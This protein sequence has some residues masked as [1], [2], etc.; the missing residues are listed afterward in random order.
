MFVNMNSKERILTAMRGETPDRVPVQLGITNM[1]SVRAQGHSGWD[2]FVDHAIPYWKIVTDTARHFGLDGYL[3]LSL[4]TRPSRSNVASSV[5]VVHKDGDKIVQRRTIETRAGELWQERTY[6][7]NETPTTTRGLLKNAEDFEIWIE[8][9]MDE[10]LE[11]DDTTIRE[12]SAYLGRDGTTA[13]CLGLPG[14]AALS[15]IFDGKLETATYV[16]YDRP[17]LLEAY[18]EREDRRQTRLLERLLDTPALDY[19]QIGQ[20]GMLTLS[21]PDLFRQLCLP[22]LRKLTRICKE[23]GVLTELHCCGYERLVVETCYNETDLDSINPLQPP[24]MGDC[25]LAEVKRAF[26]DHLCLKGNVGVTEPLLTGTPD[27]VERDVVR[28][29]E[30]AKAGGRFILFSEEGIGANTPHEN[31]RRYVEAGRH[32]GAYDAGRIA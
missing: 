4:N 28:C 18:R 24:P 11:Y 1:F 8:H 27:D 16:A 21:T 17:D 30:A 32:Y 29:M 19:I 20:S 3:Y 22:T 6:L 12:A 23:A 7:R 14:L 26:G 2:V 15:G 13:G 5:K 31:V 10:Q 25:D 9:C